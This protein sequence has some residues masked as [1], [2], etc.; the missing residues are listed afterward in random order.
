MYSTK[1]HNPKN[2]GNLSNHLQKNGEQI[3]VQIILSSLGIL[4]V[5]LVF[6]TFKKV[7]EVIDKIKKECSENDPFLNTLFLI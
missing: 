5:T 4:L 7:K 2:N 6:V 3:K 1:S